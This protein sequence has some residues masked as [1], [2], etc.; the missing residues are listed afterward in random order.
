[1]NVK[2]DDK[3]IVLTGKDKGKTGTVVKSFPKE[4]RVIVSGV[5]I[6]KVHQK[7]RKS[8]EKG[9]ILDKTMPIDVSNV[10]RV[11]ARGTRKETRKIKGSKS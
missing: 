4:N 11:E 10:K 7:P 3:V 9:Q 8:G 5:N 1:M 6:L 2:K